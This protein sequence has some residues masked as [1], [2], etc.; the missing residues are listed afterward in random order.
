MST[1]EAHYTSSGPTGAPGFQ[2]AGASP[3]L[4]PALLRRIERLLSHAPPPAPPPRPDDPDPRADVPAAL[5][6]T[7]LD[8]DT[9]VLTHTVHVGRDHA[10]VYGAYH[11]HAVVLWGESTSPTLPIDTWGSSAWRTGAR[12]TGPVRGH[13]TPGRPAAETGGLPCADGAPSPERLTAFTRRHRGRVAAV[14]TDV[15]HA[16]GED[17][18]TARQVVLVGSG[19]EVAHWIALACHSLPF[20]L[21]ALLTFTT[22]TRRPDLAPHHVIGVT[23]GSAFVDAATGDRYRVHHPRTGAEPATEPGAEP[24]TELLTWAVAAAALWEAG[25]GDLLH[26]TLAAA[27]RDPGVSLSRRARDLGG[28]LA[29]AALAEGVELPA[30]TAPDAVSWCRARVGEH[31]RAWWAALLTAL[32]AGGPPRPEAAHDLATALERRFDSALTTPLVTAALE[33]LPELLVEEPDNADLREALRWSRDRLGSVR[34]DRPLRCARE[35]LQRA[36]TRDG[37]PVHVLLE[38]FRL[39]D[40]LLQPHLQEEHAAR[41]LVP[42]LLEDGAGRAAVAR[43]LGEPGQARSRS[44][45]LRALDTR[46][47]EEPG[48]VLDLV[49]RDAPAWLL[50]PPPPPLRAL[51]AVQRLAAA[52][53]GAGPARGAGAADTDLAELALV[54]DTLDPGGEPDGASLRLALRIA[55]AGRAPDTGRAARTLRAHPRPEVAEAASSLVVEAVRPHRRIT[56]L[57]DL[58]M[59]HYLDLFPPRHRP[60]VELVALT[61]RLR[62]VGRGA[63]TDR[64]VRRHLDLLLSRAGR[65]PLGED[66]ARAVV[67]RVLDPDGFA[68]DDRVFAL[69]FAEFAALA[70][71][72]LAAAYTRRARAELPPVLRGDHRMCAAHAWLWWARSGSPAWEAVRGPLLDQVLA[73]SLRALRPA[74]RRDAYALIG[75]VAPDTAEQVRSWMEDGT[76]GRGRPRGFGTVLRRV[77]PGPVR[78][79]RDR[80]A[81]APGSRTRPRSG[82]GR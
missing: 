5:S 38:L 15:L 40:L 73:P 24:A 26:A 55:W 20:D 46:A 17:G 65:G 32:T 58:L 77:S 79:R 68:A 13:G 49:A 48:P 74:R 2:I 67:E 16:L 4:R 27:P 42:W 71:P 56:A 78:A 44:A 75:A 36:L 81:P 11:A 12:G 9:T 22:G 14:L 72:E 7:R 25:R 29:C 57:A 80:S 43:L 21:A 70:T 35:A 18:E 62:D 6:H 60:V 63:G 39:S 52:R 66:A 30:S 64:V 31:P 28:A 8:S 3:G 41:L 45:V 23:C 53:R 51:R 10:D 82:P 54:T 37:T 19:T 33:G 34:E 50:D 76:P 61:G 47:R 69:E 59:D 1:A